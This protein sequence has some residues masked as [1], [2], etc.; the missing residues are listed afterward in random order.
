MWQD[1]AMTTPAAIGQGVA[2]QR[3][4]VNPATF[5][6]SQSTASR[7]PILRQ[8]A[9]GVYYLE[10]DGVDDGL[11]TPPL[12]LTS[13]DKMAIFVGLRKLSDAARSTYCEFS[14]SYGNPGTFAVESPGP[15]LTGIMMAHNGSTSPITS[16]GTAV[17]PMT[18]VISGLASSRPHR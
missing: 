12:N 3:C 13:T 6:R 8:T 5:Y 10:C 9:G 1:V 7:R 14:S 15:G 17:A 11:V 2:M 18:A 4:K 16:T